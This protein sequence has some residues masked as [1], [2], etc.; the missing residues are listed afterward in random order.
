MSDK[1]PHGV[2]EPL[3]EYGAAKQTVSVTLNSS[4]FARAKEL[5]INVSSVAEEALA[6]EL[7]R[8]RAGLLT[9]EIKADVA[10][11]EAFVGKYGSFAAMARA[12]YNPERDDSV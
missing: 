6:R 11:A 10:A 1:Y 12:H 5:G 7:A 3:F 8:L 9:A 4:L 2:R